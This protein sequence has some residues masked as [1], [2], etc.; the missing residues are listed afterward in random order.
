M[1]ESSKNGRPNI[2]D[3]ATKELSQDAMICWLLK[4]SEHRYR[5]K[6][7]ALH[8][9]GVRF[10]RA[11]LKKHGATLRSEIK[12]VEIHQ[13]ELGID[14]LARINGK[15]V[16]L[17]EDKTGT[18]DHS[19]QLS[20]YYDDVVGGKTNFGKVAKKNLY[21]IYLKT[22][23][24]S[25][26]DD[27]RI[28]GLED[29]NYK[30]FNRADFLDVLNGYKGSNP[31][32]A[33]FRQYLQRWEDETN[34]YAEWTRDD[35]RDCWLAWE[36]LYRLLECEWAPDTPDLYGWCYVNNPS[37]GFLGFW[38]WPPPSWDY[39]LYLTIETKPEKESKLCF[40]VYSEETSDR[41]DQLKW[42]WHELVLK[43]GGQQVVKPDVMRRAK[44]MTVA[45]WKED[46]LAF[47][48]DGK[49]DIPNTVRNLKRADK[50][51]K[52]ATALCASAR[53]AGTP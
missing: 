3:Y 33:D 18:K 6:H 50:V 7:N 13:Q 46:W 4:Y 11:L 23:N 52:D 5:A 17:I 42:E 28:E 40:K 47:G 45:W 15:H 19:E 34:S 51:L 14:V 37:G 27:R 36:G 43:A 49:L 44:N 24:Q 38:R 25:L 53:P 39:N 9:C 26:A 29:C 12:K 10:V 21:P 8:D 2:F 35:E 20:R 41:Q 22:G 16:L 30:V 32:L 48:K 31:I 1:S